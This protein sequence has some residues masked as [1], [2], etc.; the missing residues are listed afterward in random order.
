LVILQTSG[1]A[2][3]VFSGFSQPVPDLYGNVRN[4]WKIFI[5]L[6]VAAGGYCRSRGL[7]K[8]TCPV[9]RGVAQEREIHY[10]FTV[11]PGEAATPGRGDLP[12]TTGRG[13]TC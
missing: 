3:Q 6:F 12:K 4:E 2:C 10:P 7:P 1:N 13:K 5:I 8:A 11:D 9:V